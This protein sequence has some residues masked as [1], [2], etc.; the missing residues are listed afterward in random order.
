MDLPDGRKGL[1]SYGSMTYAFLKC[2]IYADVKKD[3]PRVKAA[4]EWIQKHYTLDENPQMG[5]QG[6]FYYYHTMA[7]ALSAYGDD[8]LVDAKGVK[9]E[10]RK[11]MIDKLLSLQQPDG[12]WVNAKDR[13]WE[14]RPVLVTSYVVLTLE[15]LTEKK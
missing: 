13:W 5:Q 8:V 15:E 10:W 4:Y 9:H 11:D 12:S 3:D 2:M 7:K 14:N 6:L 1:R